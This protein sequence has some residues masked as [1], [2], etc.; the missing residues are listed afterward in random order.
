MSRRTRRAMLSIHLTASVGWIGA[1]LGY[2]ALAM[3]AATTS[4]AQVMRS[5]WM[6]MALVGW[7]VICPLALASL[8][9]GILMAA[10]T[11]WGLFD[12]YW[13]VISLALTVVA[14]AVL[15]LHM[16]GV[17]ATADIANTAT[18]NRLLDLGSD[19]AHPT[20]GLL[21]LVGVQVLNLYKPRGLTRRGRQR[22]DHAV[23]GGS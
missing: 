12:H 14:V 10:G 18:D 16:P 7:Y 15:L 9:T 1:V 6:G 3:T 19:L 17:S 13:V 11:P 22:L 8:F 21:L 4:D 23:A 20:I 2:L 5:A